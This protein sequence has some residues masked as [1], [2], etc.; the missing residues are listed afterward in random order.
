MKFGHMNRLQTS[1]SA[2]YP[3]REGPHDVN[4]HPI[5]RGVNRGS[6]S[7]FSLLSS[8]ETGLQ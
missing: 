5:P 1:T 8:P 4:V 2:Q 3:K 7:I 6:I